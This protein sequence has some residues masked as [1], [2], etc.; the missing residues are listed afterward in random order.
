MAADQGIVQN[1]KLRNICYRPPTEA[2]E[3]A[4]PS[5]KNDSKPDDRRSCN[6]GPVWEQAEGQPV[7]GY[8]NLADS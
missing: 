6:L 1:S 3:E 8:R 2:A 5:S 7:C 4:K